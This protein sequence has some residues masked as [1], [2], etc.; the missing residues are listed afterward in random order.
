M[1]IER[2][3]KVLVTRLAGDAAMIRRQVTVSVR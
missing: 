3:L 2:K 1:V